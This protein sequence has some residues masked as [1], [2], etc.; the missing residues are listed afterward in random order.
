MPGGSVEHFNEEPGHV[1]MRR[2]LDQF[3]SAV[4]L[5]PIPRRGW[6]Y[7]ESIAM[8]REMMEDRMYPVTPGGLDAAMRELSG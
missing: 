4:W 7:T 8:I 1:W 3:P 2:F 6:D 5:N